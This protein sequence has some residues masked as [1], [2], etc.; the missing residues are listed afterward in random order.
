MF[1]DAMAQVTASRGMLRT[2]VPFLSDFEPSD[3]CTVATRLVSL[4]G[5]YILS[6]HHVE[7]HGIDGS[8]PT[9]SRS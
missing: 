8:Q 2:M 5:V 7:R 4:A 9:V 1:A 6:T 3:R